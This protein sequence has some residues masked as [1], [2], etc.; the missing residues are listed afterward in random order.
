M[1][2]KRGTSQAGYWKKKHKCRQPVSYSNKKPEVIHAIAHPL[3]IVPFVE[4]DAEEGVPR[5]LGRTVM[6][7][8][9]AIVR[10]A[11]IEREIIDKHMKWR[12]IGQNIN[13]DISEQES[14]K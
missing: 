9:N 2:A 1:R 5:D 3:R 14:A 4:G 13:T 12:S 8:Q 6:P 10:T 11:A 7:D